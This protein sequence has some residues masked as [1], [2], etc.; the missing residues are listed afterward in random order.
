MR[1]IRRSKVTDDEVLGLSGWLY[2]DL[3]L[4]LMVVFL[5]SVSF[6]VPRSKA[7]PGDSEGP[8]PTTTT[9]IPGEIKRLFF[10][11][12]LE[13]IY[14]AGDAQKIKE[15]IAAFIE[16]EKL[17]KANV[18]LV[19]VY[20]HIREGDADNEG[21]RLASAFYKGLE[22][23]LE[24]IFTDDVVNYAYGSKAVAAG[25]YSFKIFFV[26]DKAGN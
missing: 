2:T 20:G 8:V 21:Q 15:D 23:K 7:E 16:K 13:G 26:Y 12:P 11:T 9:T 10:K 17:A 22:S 19:L 5:G 4:G 24:K 25:T 3:L 6:L 1:R 14:R 18:A